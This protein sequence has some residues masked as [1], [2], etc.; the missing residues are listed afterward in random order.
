MDTTIGWFP[1]A[2]TSEWVSGV[3]QILSCGRQCPDSGIRYRY[4]ERADHPTGQTLG[5]RERE[6]HRTGPLQWAHPQPP[7]PQIPDASRHPPQRVGSDNMIPAPIRSVPQTDRWCLQLLTSMQPDC[8]TI[9]PPC[10]GTPGPRGMLQ[11]GGRAD[12]GTTPVLKHSE[13]E[14]QV[15]SPN[16]S[17]LEGHVLKTSRAGTS[18]LGV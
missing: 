14:T 2:R 10:D 13:P 16:S 11:A 18:D 12:H 7:P 3:P 8:D 1:E 6:K 9:N 4:S 15:T 17:G 5:D